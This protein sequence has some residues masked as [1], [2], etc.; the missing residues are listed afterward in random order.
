[1]PTC[2]TPE[3]PARS[4]VF[5]PDHRQITLPTEAVAAVG[6]AFDDPLEVR[7][8]D[9]YVLNGAPCLAEPCV[10]LLGACC[11]NKVHRI[12]GDLTLAELP[13]HSR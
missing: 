1:M 9:I 13:R 12:T 8:V 4:C 6:L 2:G 7:V 3:D 11:R 5:L 10:S